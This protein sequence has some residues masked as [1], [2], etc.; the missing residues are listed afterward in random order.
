MVPVTGKGKNFLKLKDG[1][2]NNI[3]SVFYARGLSSEF[4]ECWPT[5]CKGVWYTNNNG[6]CSVSDEKKGQIVKVNMT[7]TRQFPL[8]Y[9]YVA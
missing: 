1:S 2:D 4:I 8:K 9:Y 7:Q 5:N 6:I 3:S